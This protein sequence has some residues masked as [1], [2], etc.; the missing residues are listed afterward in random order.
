MPADSFEQSVQVR[1]IAKS[2]ALGDLRHRAECN[3]SFPAD[4]SARVEPY[5][6]VACI[7]LLAVADVNT[8]ATC[9]Q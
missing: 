6:R 1:A 4:G 2:Q 3:R 8:A 9:R 7:P 5:S